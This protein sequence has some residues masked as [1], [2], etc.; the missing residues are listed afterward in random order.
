MQRGSCSIQRATYACAVRTPGVHW[1]KPQKLNPRIYPAEET[2]TRTGSPLVEKGNKIQRYRRLY[3]LMCR[4]SNGP[5]LG[6]DSS[7]IVYLVLL[8]RIALIRSLA[9]SEL[10]ELS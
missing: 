2:V 1:N 7:R 8:T 4:A 10:A 6:T 3:E 5:D 9:G